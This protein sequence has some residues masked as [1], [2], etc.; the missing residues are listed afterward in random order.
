MSSQIGPS[1]SPYSLVNKT[2]PEPEITKSDKHSSVTS[3]FKLS[4]TPPPD[5]MTA[6]VNENPNTVV[7]LTLTIKPLAAASPPLAPDTQPLCVN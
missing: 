6:P 7:P 1:L 2:P 3:P 4:K 5:G